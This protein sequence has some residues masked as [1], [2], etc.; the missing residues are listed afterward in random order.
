MAVTIVFGVVDR[1]AAAVVV[2]VVAK[3]NGQGA[4]DRVVRRRRLLCNVVFYWINSGFTRQVSLI[5]A[6]AET[7]AEML[8]VQLKAY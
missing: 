7:G 2:V 3:F 6:F 8:F 4:A 5:G 1:V